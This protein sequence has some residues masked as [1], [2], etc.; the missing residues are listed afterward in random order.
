MLSGN[1]PVRD[2][3]KM[4]LPQR[5]LALQVKALFTV[6]YMVLNLNVKHDMKLD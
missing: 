5:L 3:L 1:T 6:A 2:K 4:V